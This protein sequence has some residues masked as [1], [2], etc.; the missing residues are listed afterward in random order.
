M[1]KRTNRNKKN[2]RKKITIKKKRINKT[3]KIKN[4][5]SKNRTRNFYFKKSKL[6][7]KYKY[8]GGSD[9]FR[10]GVE[11]I[12]TKL[13]KREI[14]IWFYIILFTIGA[15]L[16]GINVW[17]A[18]A[19]LLAGG[20][21]AGI[22][23]IMLIINFIL[24]I[25]KIYF[26]YSKVK[27]PVDIKS[28][29][30]DMIN[31]IP[32]LELI[33][34]CVRTGMG[35][36]ILNNYNII[37]QFIQSGDIIQ[38]LGAATIG[39]LI[40]LI[41]SF[42][43]IFVLKWLVFKIYEAIK[44]R[45]D[46]TKI[47]SIQETVDIVQQAVNAQHH[48][49]QQAQAGGSLHESLLQQDYFNHHVQ[50][51]TRPTEIKSKGIKT[52]FY[53]EYIK[54]INYTLEKLKSK[55]NIDK[56]EEISNF[57]NNPSIGNKLH[58]IIRNLQDSLPTLI[59]ILSK[60]IFNNDKLNENE[61]RLASLLPEYEGFSKSMDGLK[62]PAEIEKLNSYFK[63]KLDKMEKQNRSELMEPLLGR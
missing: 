17:G 51:D 55:I 11:K 10:S 40:C 53:E 50:R 31:I 46:G 2:Y 39:P 38:I 35:E 9:V 28:S 25:F 5:K 42:C 48:D 21:I 4:N 60:Y 58:K 59:V 15:V 12:K 30:K 13:T 34:E 24:L 54:L 32:G 36:S 61:E 19:V 33:F 29:I 6:N 3:N 23:T 22:Q 49:P 47:I 62:I 56:Y 26:I 18:G 57:L 16:F 43:A 7:K 8:H 14:D 27:N 44:N 37:D 52:L 41:L 63:K 1:N 45:R 20:S